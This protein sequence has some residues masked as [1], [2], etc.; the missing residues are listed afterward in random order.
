MTRLENC[1]A[2][3]VPLVVHDPY[4][5]I[6]SSGETLTQYWP[7]HWSGRAQQIAGMVVVDGTCYRFL[8]DMTAFAEC[9]IP[10]MTQSGIEVLPTRTIARFEAP[11]IVLEAIFTT[12]CLTD[13]L[14]LL[15]RPT[16]YVDVGVR[17]T[18][19]KAHRIAVHLD[20]AATLTVQSPQD[21]VVWGRHRA[22]LH[23]LLW[24]GGKDQRV[25]QASG[26][27]ILID[28]GYLYLSAGPDQAATGAIGEGLTLRTTFAENGGIEPRDDVGYGGQLGMPAPAATVTRPDRDGPDVDRPPLVAAAWTV[29]LGEVGS[30]PQRASFLIAYDQIFA[31]EYFHRRLR[32]LWRAAGL[33]M[34]GL[35][36]RAWAEHEALLERCRRF[37]TDLV[38][39]AERCG[40]LAYAR[41][42]ALAYRQCLGGHTLVRDQDGRL[43]HFSKE[44]SSNGCMATVD[45]TYPSAPFFLYFNPRLLEAQLEPICALAA[46]PDWRFP[47]APHDVGRF[48]L[49][50]GQVYGGGM[51]SLHRQMPV[52]ECGNMLLCVAGLARRTD[53]LGF[54][55]RYWG[56]LET[57]ADY[58]LEKGLDPE[59][60]L[61]TDDFAGHLAHNTNLSIKAILGIGAFAQLCRAKGDPQSARRYRDAAEE[62]AARWLEM[63]EDGDHYR[64]TFDGPGTWSQKYNL[65][66]DRILGL[67]LF[68]ESVAKKEVAFYRGRQNRYGLP[69]DS[70]SSYTKLDWILWTASLTG[71]REDFAALVEPLARWLDETSDRVALSD[72]FFTDTGRTTRE[73]G[74]RGRTV[75]GGVLVKL[76]L[77]DTAA[78]R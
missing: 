78:T 10:A 75:V 32:P 71:D 17:A 45:I 47:F 21:P 19:G 52:E 41:L 43:L 20:A 50:N 46:S 29:D 16:T 14:D 55:L 5:S 61:C 76:L 56:L 15:S 38:E 1:R 31:A 59:N 33:S 18:D 36:E 22:G 73:R 40:G 28:W 37:D 13:D 44:N 30:E 64:L 58:L 68:P 24:I 27:E 66:W 25:L 62:R 67:G 9:P 23:E 6:W 72:W 42:V 49:A 74:F 3:A 69:L 4:L 12:P 65:I 70:R 57:W 39:R 2:P 34:G 53:D 26:D 11:G 35:V 8:G 63:A 77:D 51:H 48:P 7:V 60:Q 54:A